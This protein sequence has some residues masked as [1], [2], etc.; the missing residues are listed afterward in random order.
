MYYM[1]DNETDSFANKLKRVW[2]VF[3]E[4][5]NEIEFREISHSIRKK[6]S[7]TFTV[8]Q[9][10]GKFVVVKSFDKLK[11]KI[12]MLTANKNRIEIYQ[13]NDYYNYYYP[14]IVNEDYNQK[15][16][17]INEDPL[18]LFPIGLEERKTYDLNTY[19]N[20]HNVNESIINYIE[21]T[22]PRVGEAFI[23]NINQ[24]STF[25]SS[26]KSNNSFSLFHRE[27]TESLKSL[28]ELNYPSLNEIQILQEAQNTLIAQDIVN[29]N[30]T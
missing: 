25:D 5:V 20:L 22:N 19:E 26:G 2:K 17:D 23:Q 24:A 4:K 29:A 6:S 16:E 9:D 12:K 11:D 7:R 27:S 28:K 15:V 3:A 8:L 10:A 18:M 21:D 1:S 30:R 14:N 13:V